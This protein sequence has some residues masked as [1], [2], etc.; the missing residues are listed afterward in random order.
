MS[1]KIL[2]PKRWAV[3]AERILLA[4]AVAY[5][6]L[7]LGRAVQNNYQINQAIERLETSIAS[8]QERIQTIT[9]EIAYYSSDAY[10]SIEAKRRLG[11]KR[12]DESVVLVPNN[13]DVRDETA[14]E[15]HLKPPPTAATDSTEQLSSL[16]VARDNAVTWLEW[17]WPK[18]S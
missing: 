5:V 2:L 9:F 3:V 11:Y 16:E 14:E 10:R 1:R 17:L 6:L 12:P 4:L 15:L 8:L 13:V 18:G 7:N